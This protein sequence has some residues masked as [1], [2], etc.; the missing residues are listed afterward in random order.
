MPDTKQKTSRE[1][2]VLPNEDTEFPFNS[3]IAE[4]STQEDLD[5]WIAAHGSEDLF[6][7]L[8]YALEP[9]G[10]QIE[11][12]NELV[13]MVDDAAARFNELEETVVRLQRENEEG[14]LSR[15]NTPSISHEPN[16]LSYPTL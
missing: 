14:R 11:I 7:F 4:V 8:R 16:R 2:W 9:H 1:S 3:K 6:R 10:D 12:H 15:Q 5:T 13:Q